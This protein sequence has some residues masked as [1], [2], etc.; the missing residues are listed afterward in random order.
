MEKHQAPRPQRISDDVEQVRHVRAAEEGVLG[1]ILLSPDEFMPHAISELLPDH[2]YLPWEQRVFEA[3]IKCHGKGIPVDFINVHGAVGGSFDAVAKYADFPAFNSFEYQVKLIKS[4]WARRKAKGM[5]EDAMKTVGHFDTDLVAQFK[6]MS[7]DVV[8]LIV[9]DNT[10]RRI[11]DG[12][13]ELLKDIEQRKPKFVPTGLQDLDNMVGGFSPGHLWVIAGRTSMG[14]TAMAQNLCLGVVK[15]GKPAGYLAIEDSPEEIKRRFIA[16]G[17]KV[18]LPRIVNGTIDADDAGKIVAAS[19]I[20]SDSPLY[21][22]ERETD[23]RK[24]QARVKLLK[25]KVPELRV[26][27][28]DYLNI[29]RHNVYRNRW[30]NIAEVSAEAKHLAGELGIAVVLLCQINRQT[31]GRK[32]HKPTLGDLRDSGT[33]EQDADVVMLLYRKGY[34]DK[35]GDPTSEVC[36]AK[37]RNGPTGGFEL[38]FDGECLRFF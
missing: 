16:I 6:N 11:G 38:E 28:I 15:S 17:S 14:K 5:L 9:K 8:A 26:V 32:N 35:N 27:F 10:P 31:E 25:F 3:M 24:I 13:I 21:M 20:I 23:W 37:Q 18:P 2:F 29:I 36:I 7:D 33:I 12:M 4:F 34:Y 1:A 22:I 19:R 30:E